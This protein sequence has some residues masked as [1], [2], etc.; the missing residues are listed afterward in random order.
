MQF[1][2]PEQFGSTVNRSGEAWQRGNRQPYAGKTALTAE[3]SS[4]GDHIC[5]E[6]SFIF[7]E[8]YG[9]QEETM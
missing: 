9:E 2:W 4:E 7:Q 6:E 5:G 3:P 1:N 8:L